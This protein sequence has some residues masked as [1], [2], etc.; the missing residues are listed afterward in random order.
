M[1]PGAPAYDWFVVDDRRKTR[2]AG[3]ASSFAAA[4]DKL[5]SCWKRENG[6]SWCF[7]LLTPEGGR[8]Q[9]ISPEV[10]ERVI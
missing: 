6:T 10:W 9:L 7:L 1:E 3:R 2:H 4:Q 8:W 5:E